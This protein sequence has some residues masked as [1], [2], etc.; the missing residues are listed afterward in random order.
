MTIHRLNRYVTRYPSLSATL[1]ATLVG[2]LCLTTLLSLAGVVERFRLR[3]ESLK[4]LARLEENGQAG[5]AA[6]PAPP[7]SPFLD[8]QTVTTASAALLERITSAITR[9]DGSVLSSEVESQRTQSKDGYLKVS[10]TCELEQASL[11]QLLYDIEA[12]MPFLFI[13]QLVASM[14]PSDGGRMRVVLDVSG[15]WIGAK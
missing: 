3:D 14:P 11:Q 8:G 4:M 5:G 10:V 9:A 15:L 6:F 13:D 7:G 1:Y 2:A 12:R